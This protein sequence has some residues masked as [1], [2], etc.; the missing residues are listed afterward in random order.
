M[1]TQT[2]PHHENSIMRWG[3]QGVHPRVLIIP[4]VIILPPQLSHPIVSRQ[5]YI[6]C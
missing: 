2:T 4:F 6:V 1:G 3:C 5:H